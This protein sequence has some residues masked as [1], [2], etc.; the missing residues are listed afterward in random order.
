MFRL[1]WPV[2]WYTEIVGLFGGELGELHTDFFQVQA[3]D[4][5]VEFLRQ[6]INANFVIFSIFPEIELG[7]NLVGE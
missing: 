4:F 5:F 1:E 7:Q 2:D 3:G 6:N